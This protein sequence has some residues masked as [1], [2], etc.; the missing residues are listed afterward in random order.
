M[1]DYKKWAKIAKEVNRGEKEIVVNVLRGKNE[2]ED[3]IRLKK[4]N[5]QKLSFHNNCIYIDGIK[6]NYTCHDLCINEGMPISDFLSW[7]KP[8][9]GNTYAIVHLT[10]YKYV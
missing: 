9:N 8:Q 2:K 10:K 3:I 1:G 4:A 6:T 5:I 7:H